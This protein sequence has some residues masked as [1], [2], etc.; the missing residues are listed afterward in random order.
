MS[1]YDFTQTLGRVGCDRN[2]ARWYIDVWEGV[3]P[4]VFVMIGV[5]D[6]FIDL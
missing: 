3:V 4:Y 1:S 6:A 2:P 5:F